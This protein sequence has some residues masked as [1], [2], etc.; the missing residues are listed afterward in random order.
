MNHSA[1]R[2]TKRLLIKV[3][4]TDTEADA[5]VRRLGQEAADGHLETEH[6]QA[7]FC[8]RHLHEIA[9]ARD[10]GGLKGLRPQ[11]AD[12]K[13]VVVAAVGGAFGTGLGN[14]VGALFKAVAGGNGAAQPSTAKSLSEGINRWHVGWVDTIT[15]PGFNWE[16]VEPLIRRAAEVVEA[17]FGDR[18]EKTARSLISLGQCLIGQG[19]Y[20]DAM[21]WLERAFGI[22]EALHGLDHPHT[23]IALI[24]LGLLD[25]YQGK[26]AQ[27]APLL[28]R[29]LKS[30]QDSR[31]P[32]HLDTAAALYDLAVNLDAEGHHKEAVPLLRRALAIIQSLLADGEVISPFFEKWITERLS[33]S[34][35]AQVKRGRPAA[36]GH[37]RPALRSLG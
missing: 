17:N 35:A 21:P 27:L 28:R 22:E 18:D 32:D 5:F 26:Y 30:I 37:P 7:E 6:Q 8:E 10:S 33:A 2:S 20:T 14:G 9:S 29:G 31:G 4:L 11:W 1:L 13:S 34:L 16:R 36:A 3:G 19:R 23:A 24:H 15:T 12:I 25:Y